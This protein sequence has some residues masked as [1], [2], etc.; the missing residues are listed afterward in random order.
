[1]LDLANECKNI[2]TF[3]NVSTAYVNSN[4]PNNSV[5]QEKVYE[6]PGNMDPEKIVQD[7]INLGP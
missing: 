7:I 4:M 1:M 5:I 6:L 2:L 3:C